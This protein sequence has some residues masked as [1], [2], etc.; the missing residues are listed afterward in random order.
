[1]VRIV[2][3]VHGILAF[4]VLAVDRPDRGAMPIVMVQELIGVRK[5]EP[6]RE[7]RQ[8]AAVFGQRMRLLVIHQLERVLDRPEKRVGADQPA[9]LVRV[10]PGKVGQSHQA[11]ERVDA[12]DLRRLV[13][14]GQLQE[15]RDEFD[16][17]DRAGPRF[18]FAPVAA[19]ACQIG[20]NAS[21]HPADALANF[22]RRRPE[23]QRL[24]PF[25]KLLADRGIAGND[26][27]LEEGLP[28]PQHS[29]GLEIGDVP[30]DRIDEGARTAPRP[31]PH[32]N[33][34]Q[35]A[36]SGR[37]GQRLDEPL[38]ETPKPRRILQSTEKS[39]RCRN[40]N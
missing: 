22:F 19:A 25:E 28:F 27:G 7:K 21:L 37:I 3:S 15:L 13:S 14:V 30:V 5:I 6:Q 12:A 39:N 8:F 20:F 10:D 35:K 1:M 11:V 38:P 24:D 40:C 31:Q 23:K 4:E 32:I 17:A 18:D 29:V 33:A 16:V 2:R 36:L 34:I 9:I 26:A